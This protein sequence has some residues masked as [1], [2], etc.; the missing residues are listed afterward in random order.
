MRAGLRQKGTDRFALLPSTYPSARDTRLRDVLGYNLPS[1]AGLAS[2][3]SKQC[4]FQQI[5]NYSLSA[6]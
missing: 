4:R 1:L 2:I 5:F 3:R 6:F